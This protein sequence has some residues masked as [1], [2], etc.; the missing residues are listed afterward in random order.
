MWNSTVDPSV[1][2]SA[3]TR[4]SLLTKSPPL[5][6]AAFSWPISSAGWIQPY[7]PFQAL[8]V[9]VNFSA[10]IL[11]RGNM[12]PLPLLPS[13]PSFPPLPMP[14]SNQ[15]FPL[16][17]SEPVSDQPLTPFGL[18]YWVWLQDEPLA[19]AAYWVAPQEAP[20]AGAAHE[21]P[22]V[23]ALPKPLPLSLPPLPLPAPFGAG[24]TCTTSSAPKPLSSSQMWNCT[25][26]PTSMSPEP[27]KSSLLKKSEPLCK[28]AF[29]CSICSLGVMKPYLPFQALTSPLNFSAEIRTRG[30]VW[31]LPPSALP[32]LLPL[33]LP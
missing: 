5:C 12:W 28:E 25:E 4:S 22:F 9:P 20:M 21:L 16:P 26:A 11:V 3:P 10:E 6:L 8:T 31:P 29:S 32:L 1:S 17:L 13:L 2:A 27:S 19:G 24:P 15:P 14:L 30:S 18:A 33:P 7:L 23:A